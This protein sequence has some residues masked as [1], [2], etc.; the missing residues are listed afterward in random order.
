MIIKH[1]TTTTETVQNPD[2]TTTTKET[3]VL[4]DLSSLICGKITWEGSRLQVARRLEFSYVFEPRDP[5]LRQYVINLGE[6]VYAYDEDGNLVFEGNVYRIERNTQQSEIQVTC[7]DHLFVLCRSKMTRKFTDMTAEDIAKAVCAEMGVIVG[8]LAETGKK[9][10]FIA[11]E[12]TGYQIIM[13]AYTEAAKQINAAKAKASDPD[14]LFHPM[15]NGAALDI[16]KKGT[17]IENW[18][19]DQFTNTENS[20]YKESIENLIDRVMITDE[21]G[22]LTGYQTNDDWIK[23]YSMFQD[24]YKTNPNEN[25]QEQI[26]AMF[27]GPDRSGVLDLLGDY[28]VKSSY[29]I[30]IQDTITQLTGKFWVKSDTHTFENGIHEMRLEIEFENIMNKE[31]L[32]NEKNTK[33]GSQIIGNPG[34]A[35]NA[36]AGVQQGFA[37]WNG[38]TM[39]SGRRGCVEA[40]TRIGS[41]YSPY[42][43]GEYE[44]GVASVPTLMSDAG[45]NVIPF[46]ESNLEVGDCIVYDG[47]E[48]VVIYAG[49]GMYVGNNSSAAGGAG[50]VGQGGIYDI[51]MTP[52]SI[53]KTSHM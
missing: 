16:I 29:S 28:R 30:A 2:G 9:I 52:T 45:D 40:A 38:A 33:A 37:A 14:V 43:K 21:Q 11:Q 1:N 36:A 19:A 8:N 18:Q 32:P 49:N 17:L 26:K 24:V 53:I 50:A 35:A 48:H 42:L 46:D 27:H 7:Y 34:N 23:K 3:K 5:K 31:D 51:G 22:N 6:T 39:P 25:A 47:D 4:T 20:Q 41:Y 12:K 13:I 44:A 15:M 10:S